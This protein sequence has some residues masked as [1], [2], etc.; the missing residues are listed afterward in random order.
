MM[1]FFNKEMEQIN[2]SYPCLSV[3]IRGQIFLLNSK[4]SLK[5]ITVD[6]FQNELSAS[7]FK[8]LETV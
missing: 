8:K 2:D 7:D 1:S 3:S 5:T 6:A 4:T